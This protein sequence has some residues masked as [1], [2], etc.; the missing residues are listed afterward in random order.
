MKSSLLLQVCKVSSEKLAATKYIYIS[1]GD[2]M[3]LKIIEN[4]Y[5]NKY[6]PQMTDFVVTITNKNSIISR[7]YIKNIKMDPMLESGSIGINKRDRELFMID[8]DSILII[9]DDKKTINLISE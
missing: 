2:F 1:Y 7:Q 9:N 8:I 4:N 6:K 3:T 5:Y